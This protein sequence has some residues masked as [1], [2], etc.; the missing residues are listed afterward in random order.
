MLVDPDGRVGL[1]SVTALRLLG[2]RDLEQFRARWPLDLSCAPAEPAPAAKTPVRDVRELDVKVE[3]EVYALRA[4]IFRVDEDHC[5]GHLVVLRDR[6]RIEALETDLRLANQMRALTHL[7]RAMAHDLKAPLNGM[8]LNLE[9]LRETLGR[10]E[11][12]PSDERER[13]LEHVEIVQ[14]ELA[15][16]NRSL[17]GFFSRPTADREANTRF[18]LRRLL[19]EIVSLVRPQARAQDIAISTSLPRRSVPVFGFRDRLKQALLNVVL[20]AVEAMPDGGRLELS[21]DVEGETARVRVR[22][23][24][25]GLPP[26]RRDRLFDLYFTTKEEGS[27][28]GLHV[29]RSVVSAHGGSIELHDAEGGGA[30]AEIHLPV[31]AS[32]ADG[33]TRT[34][35]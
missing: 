28:I 12:A 4:E 21:L 26:G 5:S 19:R 23:H 1:A 6:R 33:E 3:N 14:R 32:A 34:G 13:R 17:Q 7:Y 22:D 30:L 27:G 10:D 24:G 20:N 31:A 16:L 9:L 18:E 35:L 25:P 11:D 15:R 29:V 8:V 2:C